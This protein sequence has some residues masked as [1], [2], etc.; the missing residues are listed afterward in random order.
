MT[1]RN[2]D[3]LDNQGEF[4]ARVLPTNYPGPPPHWVSSSLPF[5][6]PSLPFPPLLT[7]R[8]QHKPG[9]ERGPERI[10]EFH[11]E[12]HPP[13]TAPPEHTFYPNPTNEFPAEG[14]PTEHPGWTD[15]DIYNAH[16]VV[17]G[18][19]LEKQRSRELHGFHP[20][21][22]KKER[23]G[24]EGVGATDRRAPTVEHKVRQGAFDKEEAQ[25]GMRGKSGKVEGG[26]AWPGAEDLPPT[27]AEHA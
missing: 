14:N 6:S 25:K 18:H 8:H 12:K 17:H 26:L 20:V 22:R 21:K 7:F 15:R 23:S 24:L 16:D 2:P 9:N 5:P 3:A 10:P 27:S 11:A 4:H 19:P 13:G 1:A